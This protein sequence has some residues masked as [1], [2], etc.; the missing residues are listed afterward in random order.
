LPWVNWY[1]G[2]LRDVAAK[3]GYES[4]YEFLH[5]QLSG[6]VH[7]SYFALDTGIR[8]NGFDLNHFYWRFSLRVL[9]RLANYAGVTLDGTEQQ[10]VDTSKVNIFDQN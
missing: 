9:N 4:E 10:L 6:I 3:A 1:K 8:F 2:T 5:K 7:S